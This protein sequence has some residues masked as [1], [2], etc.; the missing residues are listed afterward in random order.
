MIDKKKLYERRSARMK[1]EIPQ[2]DNVEE[3]RGR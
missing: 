1:I 2:E 3:W